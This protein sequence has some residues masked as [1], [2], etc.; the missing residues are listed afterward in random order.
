[1]AKKILT[2]EEK[3]YKE[4]SDRAIAKLWRLGCLDYKLKGTQKEIKQ[5]LVDFPDEIAEDGQIF[6]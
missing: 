4:K 3:E 5:Y 6:F 2:E 1:M